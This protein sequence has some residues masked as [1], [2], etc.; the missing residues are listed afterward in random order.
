MPYALYT[1]ENI[2]KRLCKISEAVQIFTDTEK[3]HEIKQFLKNLE[4]LKLIQ[5]DEFDI[6]EYARFYCEKDTQVLRKG[7]ETFREWILEALDIDID[8]QVTSSSVARTYL[9]NRGCFEGVANLGGVC[10]VP[11]AIRR[12]RS[13]DD[14]RK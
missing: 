3:E 13:R 12:G 10:R 5:G 11:Q 14:T 1:K 8:G 2:A 4:E 7:Y 6:M 9:Q